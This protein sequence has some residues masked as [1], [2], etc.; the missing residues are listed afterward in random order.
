MNYLSDIRAQ[1]RPRQRPDNHEKLLFHPI[2]DDPSS[3]SAVC[4]E[5]WEFDHGRMNRFYVGGFLWFL[6]QVDEPPSNLSRFREE[7]ISRIADQTNWF[8]MPNSGKAWSEGIARQQFNV[9]KR[10]EPL[11]FQKAAIIIM[12]CEIA[13]EAALGQGREMPDINDAKDVYTTMSIIPACWN[14]NDFNRDLIS[15]LE[16]LP[17]AFDK[18]KEATGQDSPTVFRHLA[19][20]NTVTWETAAKTHHVIS[21]DFDS[22]FK[23]GKVRAHPGRGSLGKQKATEFERVNIG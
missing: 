22:S 16:K 5:D 20:G 7:A 21:N 19:V 6:R 10:R 12:A 4:Y 1:N 23:V 8:E 17:D 15:R 18:L 2:A 3:E 14:I 9:A 11:H 13:A